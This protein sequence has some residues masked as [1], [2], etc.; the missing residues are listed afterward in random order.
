MNASFAGL[1]RIGIQPSDDDN[2][3]LRKQFLVYQGAS[4]SIGGLLWGIL[5]VVFHY[6]VPS[7]VPFGYMV[8]TIFNFYFFDKLKNFKTSRNIQ[9]AVSLLLPFLLQWFLG[10]FK[11]SGGVMLWS[12]LALIS[13]ATYQDRK[14]SIVLFISFVVLTLFSLLYDDY[15]D[16]NFNMGVPEG[17]SLIFLVV[18][19]L[20]VACIVFALMLYFAM[21]NFTNLQKLRQSYSKLIN[22]EKL[23]ALGQISAGV[24]HEI[25]TPLGAIRSSVE[26]STH[27]FR[28]FMNVFP[29]LIKS[30]TPKETELFMDLL[31]EVEPQME[32]LSTRE[33]REKRKKISSELDNLDVKNSRFIAERLVKVGIYEITPKLAEM[34]ASPNFEAV[35]TALYNVLNQQQ[36]NSTITIAVE[37]ASRIVMALKSYLHTSQADKSELIDIA[38]NIDVVLTIYNNR[39][40]QGTNVVKEY[41]PVSLVMGHPDQLNQVWTN[42]I[43]NAL[44]AMNNKG[45]LKIGIREKDNLVEISITD[46]GGGIPDDIKNKIFDPFFTTKISGEGTGLGLDIIKRILDDHNASITF[47]SEVGKGT[48]FIVKLPV[49]VKNE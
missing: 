39:L 33:E 6:P 44:Q 26:E 18:N 10:G 21:M 20:C 34:A 5:L 25:N 37:K 7:I 2:T 45:M 14:S 49:P 29:I 1:S 23:A 48:T 12:I 15:F 22:S 41:E 11:E 27:G 8:I 3:I 47:S 16:K 38:K 31:S 28:E 36:N 40:K 13:S 43:I 32:F 17:V 9:T 35:I 46:T 30:L 24:A 42:L 4:M 19:I